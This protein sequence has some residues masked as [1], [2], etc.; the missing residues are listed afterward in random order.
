[1]LF[2]LAFVTDGRRKSNTYFLDLISVV[3]RYPPSPQSVA[4]AD[5]HPGHLGVEK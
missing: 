1:M 5:L 4:L 2:Y 3:K